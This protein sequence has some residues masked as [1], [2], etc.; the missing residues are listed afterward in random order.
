MALP[1]FYGDELHTAAHGDGHERWHRARHNAGTGPTV[2]LSGVVD[3]GGRLCQPDARYPADPGDFLVLLSG[4]L[5]RPVGDRGGPAG[6]GG[7]LCLLPHH[8]YSVRGL[9]L[10]RN[11]A[12]RH[13]VDPARPG[14]GRLCAGPELLAVHGQCGVA[15]GL[16]QHGAAVADADHCAV[17]G[18][19]AGLRAVHARLPGCGVQGG[20]ARRPPGRDV[21]VC[22][23]GVLRHVLHPVQPGPAAGRPH[24]HH[25]LNPRPLSPVPS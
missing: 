15:A 12:R 6:A 14:G 20:A 4:A 11:H 3:G 22:R 10:L 13:S 18:R 25:P 23:C 1:V 5:H 2:E 7:G 8:L 24:C 21:P 17:P 9:L 16:S 19:I